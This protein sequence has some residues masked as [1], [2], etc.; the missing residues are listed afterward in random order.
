MVFWTVLT[1]TTPEEQ[2]RR[3]DKIGMTTGINWR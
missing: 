1:T 3:T 2:Q